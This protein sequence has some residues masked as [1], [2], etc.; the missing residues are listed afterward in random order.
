MIDYRV[1][2]KYL[3]VCMKRFACMVSEC[4]YIHVYVC[5]CVNIPLLFCLPFNS[6]CFFLVVLS[7]LNVCIPVKD[8]LCQSI[9]LLFSHCHVR[10]PLQRNFSTS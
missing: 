9:V 5:V 3:C 6:V 4:V 1:F 8:L 7:D 10:L 2:E